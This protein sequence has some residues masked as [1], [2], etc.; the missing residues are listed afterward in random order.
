MLEALLKMKASRKVMAAIIGNAVGIVVLILNAKLGLG[1]E[2]ADIAIVQSPWLATILGYGLE[3][4]GKA[5]ANKTK[6]TRKSKSAAE[7]NMSAT[8]AI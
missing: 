3:D 8:G 6:R 5:A 1:L 2:I 4:Q 7:A